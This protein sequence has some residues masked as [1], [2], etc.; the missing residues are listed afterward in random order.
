MNSSFK[1]GRI[2][3]TLD[4]PRHLLFSLNALDA[5]QEQFG[6]I[7]KLAEIM[8]GKD[9]FKNVRSLLTILLNEGG[10]DT[11]ETPLTEEQVG[12]LIHTGNF[13]TVQNSIIQAFTKG[14]NTGAE[15]SGDEDQGGEAD[16][17]NLTGG[18]EK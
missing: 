6:D 8:S 16:E 5:L 3:I 7:D 9:K 11:G 2:A 4:K 13:T 1:D 18:Q 15:T 17:K 10:A 14:T 12:R